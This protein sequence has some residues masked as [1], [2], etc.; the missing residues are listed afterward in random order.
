MDNKIQS[1]IDELQNQIAKLEELT[2]ISDEDLEHMRE[3]HSIAWIEC[4]Y[5]AYNEKS[6]E[7]A[8]EI[9][10]HIEALNKKFK[11]KK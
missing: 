8:H 5:D 7:T 2:V 6:Y 3:I 10:P 9:W 11:L 1:L 4:F